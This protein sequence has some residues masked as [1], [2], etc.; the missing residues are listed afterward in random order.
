M[1]KNQLILITIFCEIFRQEPYTQG[2]LFK[3]EYYN[4]CVKFCLN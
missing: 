2:I 4:M 1:V 3:I